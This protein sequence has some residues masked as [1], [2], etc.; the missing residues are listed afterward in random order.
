MKEK[1]CVFSVKMIAEVFGPDN[2]LVDKIKFAEMV[3]KKN[4]SRAFK[5]VQKRIKQKAARH[6]YRRENGY[7]FQYHIY[8]PFKK[9]WEKNSLN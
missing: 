4:L 1:V 3:E 5:E 9:I 7:W 2:I 8:S 6:G